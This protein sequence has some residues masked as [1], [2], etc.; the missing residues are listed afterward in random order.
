MQSA[1]LS[2]NEAV[3]HALKGH[4]APVLTNYAL[5]LVVY[6]V[7]KAG[8]IGSQRL[9]LRSYNLKRTHYTQVIRFL[10][11]WGIATPVKGFPQNSVITLLGQPAPNP[12]E[13]ICTVDPFAYISHLSA[14][15]Y[16]GLTDRIPSEVFITSPPSREWRRLADERMK[17]DLLHDIQSYLEAGFPRLHRIK[18][19]SVNKR[20]VRVTR[21]KNAGAYLVTEQGAVRAS[22]IGRTFLDMLQAPD[23]CGGIQHVIDVFRV[24]AKDRK[25][26]IISEIE[27]HGTDIDKVRAGYILE[28]ICDIHDPTIDR[29]HENVVQRGGSR[30]LYAGAPYASEFS[31]RW[32]LS[33]NHT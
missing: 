31:E 28:D 8:A 12:F 17:K 13:V 20:T 5:G 9:L 18:F 23:H 25:G 3:V 27:R 24:H 22:S 26:L 10:L 21:R 30:K 16:H 2:L 32:C 6:K 7:V 19:S 14:M 15:E 4:K 29:W 11:D 1:S 33:L